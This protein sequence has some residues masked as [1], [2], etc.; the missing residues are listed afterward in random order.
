MNAIRE[1]QIFKSCYLHCDYCINI[2]MANR[3]TQRNFW[4]F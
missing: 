3:S 2:I 1:V 4:S